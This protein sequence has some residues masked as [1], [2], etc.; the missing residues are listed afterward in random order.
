MI[1]RL[2]GHFWGYQDAELFYQL[3]KPQESRGTFVIT[4]GIAEYSECYDELATRLADDGWLVFGWDLRGHGK[5][6]G[7]RGYVNRFQD[8]CED[9]DSAIKFIKADVNPKGKPLV[10]FGHSMGGLITLKTM[11]QN[12][13]QGIAAVA[14]SSPAL[15]L[16]L[17]VPKLKEQAARLLADW[18]PKVTLY[19]E[20]RYDHLTRDDAKIQQYKTDPMRH[21]KISPRLFLGMVEAMQEVHKLAP[22]L[23]VPLIMQL[24]GREKVVSTKDSEIFFEALTTKVKQI[25]IYTESLHEIFNDL[26]KEDAIRDLKGFLSKL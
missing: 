5:S 19:N 21:D 26:D 6:E 24:S 7:K 8:Y 13:P 22:E 20:I 25:Y 18:L 4:H 2:E 1:E 9:L 23:H 12:S 11:L 10:L 16:S 17:Q 15:G 3:W 14:L